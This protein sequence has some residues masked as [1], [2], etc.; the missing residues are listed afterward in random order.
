M[1]NRFDDLRR[2]LD[3]AA[4]DRTGRRLFG[5]ATPDTAVSALRTAP[6]VGVNPNALVQDPA[7][8]QQLE[9][10]TADSEALRGAPRVR[11]FVDQNEINA[12]LASDELP[13]LSGLERTQNWLSSASQELFGWNR[14]NRFQ[15]GLGRSIEGATKIGAGA[16]ATTRGFAASG[17]AVDAV[18][19]LQTMQAIASG[20]TPSD[21]QMSTQN[22]LRNGFTMGEDGIV[23]FLDATPDQQVA[24]MGRVAEEFTDADADVT[25]AALMVA[26]MVEQNPQGPALSI[27][28]IP[29]IIGFYGVQSTALA[30]PAII[31]GV[32]GGRQ[33]GMAALLGQGFGTGFAEATKGDILEEGPAAFY[34]DDTLTKGLVVAP[35]FAALDVLGPVG[36]VL[37]RPFADIPEDL[38]IRAL[39]AKTLPRQ[40]G[41]VVAGGSLEEGLAEM[42]QEMLVDWGNGEL[43][44]TTEGIT[45]YLEAAAVGALVGGP[46][47]A[48]LETP[49]LIVQA[50][51]NSDAQR[52]GVTNNTLQQIQ[53]Q[54]GDVRMRE[55]SPE[56]WREFLQAIGT[57]KGRMYIEGDA[58]QAAVDAGTVD[59]A[60]LG[61]TPEQVKTAIDTGGRVQ[62]SQL[63]WAAN[64]AGTEVGQTVLENSSSRADGYTPAQLRNFEDLVAQT[65]AE[66]TFTAEQTV[67]LDKRTAALRNERRLTMRGEGMSQAEASA[68]ATLQ[69]A[70]I[71]TLASRTGDMAVFDQFQLDIEGTSA[72]GKQR[73]ADTVSRMLEQP[74]PAPDRSAEVEAQTTQVQT[75]EGVVAQLE[76]AVSAADPEV[77][78]ELKT[79]LQDAVTQLEAAGVDLEQLTAAVDASIAQ[80]QVDQTTPTTGGT[81]GQRSDTGG[82]T[83]SGGLSALEG[84]P[85][86]RGVSGPDPRLVAVAEQYAADNGIDLKRQSTFTQVDPEFAARVADAYEAMEHNPQDPAVKEAY[87]SLIQQTTAQYQALIDAGYQFYF[88]DLSTQAGQD[89]AASPWNAMFDARDNQIMG[90]FSTAEGFGTSEDF[91]ADANPL[92]AETGIEWPIGPDGEMRPVYA[93]DLFR[94]VH[95]AFGHGLEFTGFRANGEENAWQ[96]HQRLFTGPAVAAITTETRGQNSWLNYGPNGEANRTASVEDTVFADQKTGLLPEFAWTENVSPDDI[97]GARTFQQAPVD[98]AA[99][100]QWAGTDEV[101]DPDEVNFTD[102]SGAG[103]FVMRAYHGTTH[104]FEEFNSTVKGSSE[105]HFG[106]VNYFT[107]SEADADG[108]YGASGPDL[109]ARIENLQE[110]AENDLEAVLEGL[111]DED[112]IIEAAEDWVAENYPDFDTG[113]LDQPLD[114]I[115]DEAVDGN[116]LLVAQYYAQQVSSTLQGDEAQVLEVFVRTEKPFVV[117]GDGSPFIEFVDFE[118]LQRRSVEQ[119]ADAEGVT[120]EEVEADPDTYEDMVDEARYELEA[121]EENALI[122]AVQEVAERYDVDPSEILAGLNELSMEGGRHTELEAALRE[123]LNAAY[124]ED[125]ETGDIRSTQ[126]LSEVIE[127]L[128]F[129]SIIM[130]NADQQ[131]HNMDMDSGTAHVHIF[132]Q[133]NTNIKSVDN[134]GT[135]DAADPRI[136]N[137]EGARGQINLPENVRTGTSLIQLFEGK[138]ESTMAHEFS[139]YLLEVMRSIG[140]TDGAPQQITEDLAI[141]HAWMEETTGEAVDGDYSTP[142]QEAW[143]EAFENYLMSG[144]APSPSLKVVF[145]KFALWLASVYKT[146]VGAG[147]QP[148]PEVRGVMDRLLATDQEIAAVQLENNDGAMF[149]DK[150][151]FMSADEWETYRKVAERGDAEAQGKLLNRAMESARKK[152]TK[153]WKAFYAEALVA[154]TADLSEEREY[155]LIAALGDKDN[156]YGRGARLD[157]DM[158]V[159]MFGTAILDDLKALKAPQLIYVKDG[160]DIDQVADMFGF[161]NGAHMVQTLRTVKPLAEQAEANAR[162][163]ADSLAPALTPAEM[164][165]EAEAS[166]KNPTRIERV[167]REG[168]ALSKASG[169]VASSWTVM[170]R[171][172]KARAEKLVGEMNVR[173]AG[174]YRQFSVAAR[175]AAREAQTQ[176]AKVV[177]LAD[178]TPT[179]GGMVAM[180]KAAA[181]KRQQLLNDHMYNT[182]RERAKAFDKARKRF[183]KTNTKK[184]REKVD[185]DYMDQADALL[186]QYDFRQRTAAQIRES[187][188]ARASLAEFILLQQEAG[189]DGELAIAPQVLLRGNVP[190]NYTELTV[191]A[192]ESIVDAIDNL[193]HAGKAVKTSY[194]ENQTLLYGDMVSEITTNMSLKMKAKARPDRESGQRSKIPKF[195]GA[196]NHNIET[197]LTTIRRMDGWEDNGPAMRFIFRPLQRAAAAVE[198]RREQ[199]TVA[200]K[201][202]YERHYSRQEIRQLNDKRKSGIYVSELGDTFSKAGLLSMA[203]NSGNEGNFQRLT[204]VE[205]VQGNGAYDA[206]RVNAALS[207]HMTETDWR[208]VQDMWDHIGKFWPE[209]SALEREVSGVIPKQ[210]DS[211]LQVEAPDFVTGGYYPISY[212][213]DLN[214][215]SFL[216][217]ADDAYKDATG[218]RSG[219]AQTRNGHTEA[220]L[221][222]TGMALDLNLGVAENHIMKVTHDLAMRKPINHAVKMLNNPAIG[223]ALNAFGRTSDLQSL[224]SWLVDSAA[225]DSI[226]ADSMGG[227]MRYA[228]KALTVKYI[229][230]SLATLTLQPLGA[231]QAGVVVGNKALASAYVKYAGRAQ[232]W[233]SF[234]QTNSA[235]MRLRVRAVNREMNEFSREARTAETAGSGAMTRWSNAVT[236]ASLAPIGHVQY[237]TVDIPV[238]IAAFEKARGEGVAEADAISLA[239]NAVDRASGSGSFLNRASFERGT[240]SDSA[241][242]TEYIKTF[243]MLASYVHSKYNA[244]IEVKGRTDFSSPLDTLKFTASMMQLFVFEAAIVA[245]YRAM[246]DERDDEEGTGKWLASIVGAEALGLHPVTRPL[247]SYVSGYGTGTVPLG[248]FADILAQ[249][250]SGAVDIATGVG[251]IND[252]LNTFDA[253]ATPFMLPTGQMKK[254]IRAITADEP[255]AQLGRV[256]MGLSPLRQ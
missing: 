228:R 190:L 106:A 215:A 226:S 238:F 202:L 5:A 88:I 118:D 69:A 234:I 8:L 245:L 4:S 232:Y 104:S 121:D 199:E 48:V 211:V 35:M 193:I 159:S 195:L 117:G 220:R 230:F 28:N 109:T 78:A 32:V 137:Q 167:A 38:I 179:A 136:L 61:I 16:V 128:G 241:R 9:R 93:N 197:A 247:S 18:E 153:E 242:R 221:R 244:Y 250:A 27:D 95:D 105:G 133:Y 166:L 129:D 132:D 56:K 76:A 42:G 200:L 49:T 100:R 54:A 14:D 126:A 112:A 46:M 253:A 23:S 114:D 34:S 254:I 170:N 125:P 102:F 82:R 139:H 192:L 41:A 172:A 206:S 108:N 219:K 130:K 146:A 68:N 229:G 43:D 249:G 20:E 155:V 140:D 33:V 115:M 107:T 101:L 53:D 57:D 185:P 111:T 141:I 135:F 22:F 208:F 184:G 157:R 50:R 24:M 217:G 214:I 147:T 86:V 151:P 178:G 162:A 212:D 205:G 142:Q 134:V 168:A 148:S 17:R 55:R 120:A 122:S 240:S 91:S 31:A 182:A 110:R 246:G 203:L 62:I 52:D 174:N 64:Y 177:R 30:L 156:N 127:L 97:G 181:A 196:L 94:A 175:K 60:L 74:T 116:V 173:Q 37:R 47:T 165:E 236:S 243:T 248:D 15:S 207:K 158:L 70:A 89:Y 3:N 96:A 201:E 36:R 58:L 256:A 164:Q 231:V 171:A 169:G 210:V 90:V 83:R 222:S 25:E 160:A 251:D 77:R 87:D 143:A 198:E 13:A 124:I 235:H 189:V 224:R 2:D 194:L 209:I 45:K 40:V 98:T 239:E 66:S 123:G 11:N 237:W 138:D 51:R 26:L 223:Q 73:A 233:N 216:S 186:S 79:Q 113:S 71:R 252:W 255:A 149:G 39:N 19:T 72:L 1:A 204:D 119:V 225:G 144:V 75:L 183:A 63:D 85:T 188:N 154:A 103:P 99:F 145:R 191:D 80:A 21:D 180:G 6:T 131:F 176:L 59:V 29:A 81:D 10:T 218:G 7:T 163:A 44:W 152:Q 161:R 67:E 92:L 150:P 213:A 84:A 227:V 12:A 187:T 65:E